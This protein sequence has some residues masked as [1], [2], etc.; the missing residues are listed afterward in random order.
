MCGPSPVISNL[1]W[2]SWNLGWGQAELGM[3][4]ETSDIHDT[5]IGY[6]MGWRRM[7]YPQAHPRIQLWGWPGT[8]S[9]ARTKAGTEEVVCDW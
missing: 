2:F 8:T 6:R 9:T 5:V 4:M 1:S 3:I 7:K